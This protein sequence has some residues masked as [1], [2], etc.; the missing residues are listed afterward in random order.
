MVSA[1]GEGY[2]GP[3]KRHQSWGGVA[4]EGECLPEEVD[5]LVADQFAFCPTRM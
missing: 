4:G 3:E 5:V 2:R 1:V